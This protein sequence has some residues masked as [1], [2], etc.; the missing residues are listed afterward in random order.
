MESGRLIRLDKDGIR[1]VLPLFEGMNDTLVLTALQGVMGEVWA[2]EDG[3]DRA[4]YT[5]CGDFV[6]FAGEPS[7]ELLEA[8]HAMHGGRFAILA[9][10]DGRW[11]ELIVCEYGAGAQMKTRYSIAKESD[12]FNCERLLEYSRA[13]PEGVTLSPIDDELYEKCLNIDWARD[14]CSLFDSCEDFAER[15]I[16]IVALQNGEP[17]GGASSYARYKGGIE[18][19][20]DV[21]KDMRRKG[22]ATACAARLI[23]DCL[24]RGLYPS[25]DAANRESVGLAQKLGYHED[26]PY[27]VWHVNE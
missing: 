23:L 10:P 8:Y 1:R 18:I 24:Q 4:A 17:V 5:Q 25:W 26:A 16:G 20:V 21:H 27:T 11:S 3:G 19:E 13:L 6:F 7:A 14:F 22:I 12:V 15:G 9:P 2:L